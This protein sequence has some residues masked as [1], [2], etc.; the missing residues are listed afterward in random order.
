MILVDTSVW[1]EHFRYG[2]ATLVELLRA[3]Q[4]LTHPSVIGELGCG[5]PPDRANTLRM[6]QRLRSAKVARHDEV[7]AL[8]ER[9]KLYGRGIG[10]IDAQ[11][12]ASAL[13]TPGTKVWTFDGLERGKRLA[14]A[15]ADLSLLWES[16]VAHV[17]VGT[18]KVVSEG[19]PLVQTND[20]GDTVMFFERSLTLPHEKA[21]STVARESGSVV[22]FQQFFD[23]KQEA[24]EYVEQWLKRPR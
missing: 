23:T 21:W 10:Y 8:I 6:L 14:K 18:V 9:Q 16:P 11:L 17:H 22:A 5:T 1:V 3:G 20:A 24:I 12:L 2:N 13:L 15:A 7:L 4:V 19:L